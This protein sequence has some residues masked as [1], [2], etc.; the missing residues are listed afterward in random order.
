MAQVDFQ[1][2]TKE[3]TSF[4]SIV[5]TVGATTQ[6]QIQNRGADA[7]VALESSSEPTADTQAGVMVLPNNIVVYKKGTQDL[8]LRAF[9]S[10]CSVN[11]TSE[12]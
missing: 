1:G 9:N 12:D 2:L 8:Y 7:L 6:Y 3:W 4:A 10:S 11:V 5:G